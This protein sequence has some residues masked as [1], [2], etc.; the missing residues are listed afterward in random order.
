MIKLSD[1]QKRAL[2]FFWTGSGQPVTVKH[3]QSL[4]KPIQR[5]TLKALI[6]RGLLTGS[7]EQSGSVMLTLKGKEVIE[8]E[9]K[10][11]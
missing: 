11:V 9:L 10:I 8:H 3:C 4:G 5:G 1:E 7:H 6:N 2:R